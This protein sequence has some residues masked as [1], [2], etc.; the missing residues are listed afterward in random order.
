MTVD[1]GRVTRF[2]A[3]FSNRKIFGSPIK[4]KAVQ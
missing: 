2:D 3:A 4:T 1:L